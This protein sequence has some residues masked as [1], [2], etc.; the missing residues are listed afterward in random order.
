MVSRRNM[1]AFHRE[2][3]HSFP[4][5]WGLILLVMI[6]PAV[7]A[8]EGEPVQPDYSGPYCGIYCVYAFMKLSGREIDI[9]ELIK[10][11]YISSRQGS[12]LEELK[13]AVE[14]QGM[15]AEAVYKLTRQGLR[16]SPYRIILHVKSAMGNKDYDHFELYLGSKEGKAQ[17]FDPPQPA[18]LARF[19]DLAPRWDGAGLI[20]SDTPIETGAVFA[21][22]RKKLIM[23]GMIGMVFILI[24]H[25][26]KRRRL[27][28]WAMISRGRFLWLSIGQCGI[29]A[30]MA[31]VGGMIYHFADDGGLLAQSGA[32][33]EIM[34]AHQENFI[35]KVSADKVSR[36]FNGD[37]VFIDARFSRDFKNGHLK[38][39]IN[40]PVNAEDEEY[41]RALASVPKDSRIV[42]YC[43]S[44]GCQFA[45]KVAIKLIANGFSNVSIFQGGWN[46]WS[47]RSEN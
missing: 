4:A 24:V 28:S 33:A 9:K 2:Y 29:M 45:E 12:S 20:V 7:A 21:A 25:G 8:D 6:M 31:M 38:E 41:R 14:D 35:P 37:A 47:A 16:Q 23:Y 43:Q 26:L 42:A 19:S 1:A 46:E 22:D 5:T 30:I 44:A 18:R 40:I 34:K 11:E 10:P 27:C 32:I 13:K 39:A 17:L 15:Y 3:G 36:L